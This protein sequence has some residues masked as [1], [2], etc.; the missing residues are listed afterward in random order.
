MLKVLAWPFWSSDWTQSKERTSRNNL[1]YM[2][3]HPA[4]GRLV[5]GNLCVPVLVS[6][7]VPIPA[8]ARG[9]APGQWEWQPEWRSHSFSAVGTP[10]STEEQRSPRLIS[11]IVTD[12][13]CEGCQ[14]L[15]LNSAIC[16]FCS[17]SVQGILQSLPQTCSFHLI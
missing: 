8:Q 15:S 10:A 17:Q 6:K 3:T 7:Y 1:S 5:N 2:M 4:R 14:V 13:S 16:P 12:L 11:S 9:K